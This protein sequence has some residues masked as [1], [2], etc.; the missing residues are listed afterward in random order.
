MEEDIVAS[1]IKK[2]V[3]IAFFLL[4]GPILLLFL[5]FPVMMIGVAYQGIRKEHSTC[6]STILTIIAA[7]F[8]FVF[9]FLANI[10]VVPITV[11]IVI[12]MGA[13]WLTTSEADKTA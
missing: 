9:C 5:W 2:Y 4:I 8:I 1:A 7:P 11:I 12:A 13:K 3:W 6:E 10:C